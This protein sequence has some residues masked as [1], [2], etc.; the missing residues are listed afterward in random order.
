MRVENT[1]ADPSG[2][3]S[4]TPGGL[5]SS[6]ARGGPQRTLASP[7]VSNAVHR[8]TGEGRAGRWGCRL[9]RK[10]SEPTACAH[11]HRG[12][13]RGTD[14]LETQRPRPIMS[15]MTL[16]TRMASPSARTRLPGVQARVAAPRQSWCGLRGCAVTSTHSAGDFFLRKAQPLQGR[17]SK[18]ASPVSGDSPWGQGRECGGE[19]ED[20]LGP[21]QS[22]RMLL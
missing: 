9:G 11:H 6:W 18:P 20:L 22:Q 21:Q 4:P 8:T 5:R 17:S 12:H 16:G 10:P 14:G 1:P 3:E 2:P 7:S 13:P 15:S 19:A